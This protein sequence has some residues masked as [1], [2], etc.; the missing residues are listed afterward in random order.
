MKERDFMNYT[1]NLNL[2][3]PEYTDV[4]DIAD[5]NDNF[6]TIDGRLGKI[7]VTS[8]NV[9]SWSATSSFSGLDD[10]IDAGYTYAAAI[11][12]TGC[13]ASHTGTIIFDVASA[14]SGKLAPTFETSAGTVYI[15]S[16]DDLETSVTVERME[17]WT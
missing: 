3:L 17:L 2:K 12:V 4:V 5:L 1:T 8:Y 13:T 16:K 11:A 9:P 14:S 15:F 10:Y 7:V 6:T